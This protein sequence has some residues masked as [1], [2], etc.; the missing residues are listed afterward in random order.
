MNVRRP[1][2]WG[3]VAILGVTGTDCGRAVVFEQVVGPAERLAQ[4]MVSPHGAHLATVLPADGRFT[5]QIDGVAGPAFDE[6]LPVHRS[7]Q[8]TASAGAAPLVVFSPDGHRS[9]YLARLGHEAVLM[10]DGREQLRLP[11][12]DHAAWHL[13]FTGEQGRHVVLFRGDQPPAALWIDGK[14]EPPMDSPGLVCSRDGAR[15]AYPATVDGRRTLMVDGVDAGYF[16]AQPQFTADGQHLIGLGSSVRGQS[17]LADGQSLYTTRSIRWLY[18]APAG[19]DIVTVGTYYFDPNDPSWPPES[20]PVVA[21]YAALYPNG[22]GDFVAFDGKPVQFTCGTGAQI[23]RVIF[24]TDGRH[25]AAACVK[26]DVQYTLLDGKRG[27]ELAT[28]DPA[29]LTFSPDSSRFAYVATRDGRSYAV[30]DGRLSPVPDGTRLVRFSADARHWAVAG[31]EVLVD[32]QPTGLGGD[33]TFSPDGRHVL[34]AGWN[35]SDH[36]TGLYL[37]GRL[38]Y[39][40]PHGLIAWAFSADGRHLYWLAEEPDK[41][42]DDLEDFVT[43]ADGRAVARCYDVPAAGPLVKAIA[44][45]HDTDYGRASAVWA[46]EADGALLALG[47]AGDRVLRDR[48]KPPGDTT[49]A[50]VFEPRPVAG[51]AAPANPDDFSTLMERAHNELMR[52]ATAPNAAP[53]GPAS[54]PAPKP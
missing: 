40:N 29:S 23:G 24:S 7:L 13:A 50:S 1:C 39:E 30:I 8:L 9:A 21:R 54:A 45:T 36:K 35:L 25:Y 4:Y 33:C 11:L 46:L 12:A 52:Q 15:Y 10:V 22:D 2:L 53:T 17:L 37:D 38:A 19:R 16:A 41:S 44:Q 5:V 42:L 32:G 34:V 6:I 14:P 27:P 47:P 26:G 51:P 31:A 48:V 28:V 43:Y 20:R 49:I 3:V 18:V